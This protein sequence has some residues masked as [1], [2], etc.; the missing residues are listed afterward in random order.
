MLKDGEEVLLRISA[1]SNT[2]QEPKNFLG[3]CK[4]HPNVLETMK[5][6]F[7]VTLSM[8]IKDVEMSGQVVELDLSEALRE[9]GKREGGREV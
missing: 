5:D 9:G 6:F 4:F 3:L 1:G 2:P 8:F 7:I